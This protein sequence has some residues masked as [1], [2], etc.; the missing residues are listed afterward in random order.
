[1]CGL[2]KRYVHEDL[3]FHTLLSE[4]HVNKSRVV[5]NIID[6]SD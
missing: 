5:F 6:T 3:V 2:V 4:H 1:M